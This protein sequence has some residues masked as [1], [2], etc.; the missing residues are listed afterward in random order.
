MCRGGHSIA[1]YR[2]HDS[3]NASDPAHLLPGTSSRLAS[4]LPHSL[5][6]FQHLLLHSCWRPFHKS[7]VHVALAVFQTA[8]RRAAIANGN[9]NAQKNGNGVM[10]AVA[11]SLL[12]V[13]PLLL[14]RLSGKT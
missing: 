10:A 14:P 13:L 11:T 7:Q 1:G 4:S 6:L 12:L 5:S 9:G 2:L 3:I 8:L